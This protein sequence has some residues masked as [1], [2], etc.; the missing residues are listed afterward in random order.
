MK[1]EFMVI[2]TKTIIKLKLEFVFLK[3]KPITKVE[4]DI[5]QDLI[6]TLFVLKFK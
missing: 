5:I 2:K 4:I 3:I 1:Y 6:S